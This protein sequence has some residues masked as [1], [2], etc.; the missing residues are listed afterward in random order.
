MQL[1]VDSVQTLSQSRSGCSSGGG[2]GTGRRADADLTGVPQP[3]IL[4]NSIATDVQSPL[5][6]RA[7]DLYSCTMDWAAGASSAPDF[8]TDMPDAFLADFTP[9][10]RAASASLPASAAGTGKPGGGL[11]LR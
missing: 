11:Q 1:V 5:L 10:E 7:Q 9:M 8:L 2:L 6:C 4:T 3:G